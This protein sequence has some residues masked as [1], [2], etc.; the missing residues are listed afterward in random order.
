M[1]TIPFTVASGEC[2]EDAFVTSSGSP[3][4]S[5]SG[6]LTHTESQP[7]A[8]QRLTV[9]FRFQSPCSPVPCAVCAPSAHALLHPCPLSPLAP[10]PPS[11]VLLPFFLR[12]LLS[13]A[14][15]RQ[16]ERETGE[17]EGRGGSRAGASGDRGRR[18]ESRARSLS[19]R[20]PGLGPSQ[21]RGNGR[22]AGHRKSGRCLARV[23]PRRRR[24]R[25]SVW[26]RPMGAALGEGGHA[27]QSSRLVSGATE[28]GGV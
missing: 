15:R 25:H 28:F 1:P 8:A 5:V 14:S 17:R 11:C 20:P 23:W 22:S 26:T 9:P 10:P 18:V 21:P 13:A 2:C 6:T 4:S 7:P 19:Q 16:A 27:R 3:A 24:T 12:P